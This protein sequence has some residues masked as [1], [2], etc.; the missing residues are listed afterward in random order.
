[1]P[2]CQRA[3]RVKIATV[4]KAPLSW[5]QIEMKALKPRRPSIVQPCQKGPLSSWSSS[6]LI[7]IRIDLLLIS[8]KIP[9]G[10]FCVEWISQFGQFLRTCFFCCISDEVCL[11]INTVLVKFWARRSLSAWTRQRG[12]LLGGSIKKLQQNNQGLL[13]WEKNS[14]KQSMPV[15]QN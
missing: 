14:T 4:A 12:R 6:G 3:K 5:Y 2:P 11:V 9:K 15:C 8:T 13:F 1:M 10:W 7:K